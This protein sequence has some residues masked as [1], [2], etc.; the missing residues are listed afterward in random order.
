[1]THRRTNPMH[2]KSGAVPAT[3]PETWPKTTPEVREKLGTEIANLLD[4][5]LYEHPDF[6][7]A[8]L[9]AEGG[10]RHYT[11]YTMGMWEG[12]RGNGD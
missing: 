3:R 8:M 10:G 1:M 9:P 4:D 11:E 7:K 5:V 2:D 6:A 12:G